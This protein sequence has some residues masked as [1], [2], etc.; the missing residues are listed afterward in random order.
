LAEALE[1]ASAREDIEYIRAHNPAFLEAAWALINDIGA[2]LAAYDA[3]TQKPSKNKPD[4]EALAKLLNACRRFDM[5]DAER[6][7]EELDKYQY[8]ADGSLMDGIREAFD[9]LDFMRMAQLLQNYGV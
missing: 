3:E 5:D 6:A 9:K 8:D 4:R 2:L 1:H 7:M